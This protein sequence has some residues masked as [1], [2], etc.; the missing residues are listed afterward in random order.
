[1]AEV[2]VAEKAAVVGKPIIPVVEICLLIKTFVDAFDCRGS[3]YF[4]IYDYD[5]P[6]FNSGH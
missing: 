2:E 5:L 1:M 3:I 6:G 4:R